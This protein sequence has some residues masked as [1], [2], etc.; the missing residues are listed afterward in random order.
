MI[1]TVEH[2][3]VNFLFAIYAVLMFINVHKLDRTLPNSCDIPILWLPSVD[4][5]LNYCDYFCALIITKMI[6]GPPPA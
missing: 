4:V 6:H 1:K 3:N 5:S 2:S